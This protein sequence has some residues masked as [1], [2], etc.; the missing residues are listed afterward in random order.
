MNAALFLDFRK[1]GLP[2]YNFTCP[3]ERKRPSFYPF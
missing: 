3:K 2:S 1:L